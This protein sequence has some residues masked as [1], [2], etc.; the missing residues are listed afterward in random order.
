VSA[1]AEL[2]ILSD[3][4]PGRIEAAAL[5]WAEATAARDGAEHFQSLTWAGPAIAAAIAEAADSQMLTAL[6]AEDRP[7]GFAVTQS[8]RE[9]LAIL[10]YFAVRSA[11]WG[12]G[13]GTR[14]LAEVA[15]SLRA[16]S[17]SGAEL[18]VRENNRAAINLYE[19]L[20]WR[21]DGPTSLN[22]DSGHLMLHYTLDLL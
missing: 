5:L 20:G 16:R 9:G 8:S 15:R 6:G 13:V 14:L 1:V 19:Q 4:S 22:P 10:R 21:F 17:F 11:M 12:Q 2:R 18:W 3:I 7:L